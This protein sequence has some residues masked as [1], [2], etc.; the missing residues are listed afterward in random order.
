MLKLSRNLFYNKFLFDLFKFSLYK[1]GM[2][3]DA[4][5]MTVDECILELGRRLSSKKE[6]VI[7]IFVDDRFKAEEI[8][9]RVVGMGVFAAGIEET[10]DGFRIDVVKGFTCKI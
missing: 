9:W 8:Y 10:E 3:I 4:R 7:T 1:K 2:D 5:N 6:A